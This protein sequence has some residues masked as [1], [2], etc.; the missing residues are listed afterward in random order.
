MQSGIVDILKRKTLFGVA[1]SYIFF[2]MAFMLSC[3]AATLTQS[4]PALSSLTAQE[5]SWLHEHPQ[6]RL[7]D[8]PAYPPFDFVDGQGKYVGMAADYM[9]LIAKRL[10]ITMQ[11]VPGLSWSE[12]LDGV[13]KG[14]VDVLPAAADVPSRHSFLQFTKPYLKI[15]MV[16]MGQQQTA[17]VTSLGDLKGKTLALVKGYS[18]L[19]EITQ[20]YPAVKRKMFDTPLLALKAVSL[21]E[22]DAMAI[23]LAVGSYLIQSESLTNLKVLG[24]AGIST[25]DLSI[26]VRK[27]WPELVG[28]LN[29]ALASISPQERKNIFDHYV[30]QSRHKA[31]PV[32]PELSGLIV[33]NLYW[34]IAAAICILV[35]IL[36]SL[37]WKMMLRQKIVIYVV[38]PTFFVMS[39]ILGYG[40]WQMG[41]SEAAKVT[42]EI[43]QYATIY[44]K[45]INAR[46]REIAQVAEV[47]A[48][49]VAISKDMSEQ[50]LYNALKA[51]IVENRF[52]YGTAIAF[53]PGVFAG[54]NRFS[55][56]VF[57]HKGGLSAIDIAFS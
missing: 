3:A 12:A 20:R 46:L 7:G 53:E 15:P 33:Q 42:Q 55:P 31:A 34:F 45:Q 9:A 14:S 47:T 28:I 37:K 48:N 39:L 30:N 10:G 13:K 51:N 16:V 43:Q 36:L 8:D 19:A 41:R 29:K 23:N 50:D 25:S 56:Y 4:N 54:E 44:A 22:V 6:I 2:S 17:A 57:R 38:L 1:I 18:Y 26:A 11:V 49:L 27:D 5:K 40:N 32:S 52:I 21:G 24:D 35:L